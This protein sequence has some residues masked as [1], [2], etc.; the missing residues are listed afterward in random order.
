MD[1]NFLGKYTLNTEWGKELVKKVNGT[2]FDRLYAHSNYK[3]QKLQFGKNF[4]D[5]HNLDT[6]FENMKTYFNK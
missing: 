1:N 6:Y 5:A 3:G 4:F 2:H